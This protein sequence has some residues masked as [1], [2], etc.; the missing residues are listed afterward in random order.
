MTVDIDTVCPADY[1]QT[2]QRPPFEDL[3]ACLKSLKVDQPIWNPTT[4]RKFILQNRHRAARFRLEVAT[5]LS[6]IISSGLKWIED[7]DQKELIWEEASQ[8]LSER[9]GRAAMGEIIRRWPFRDR[10]TPFELII[11]EPPITGDSLGLKTWG[12]SY[13]MAQLLDKVAAG[14]LAHLNFSDRSGRQ[15]NVLE[16]GSGTGLLGMAAAAMWRANVVLS[17]LPAIMAN[18][19][20]NIEQNRGMIKEFGGNVD[21]GALTWGSLDAKAD[22]FTNQNGYKVILVADPLYDDDHPGLL[23][24]AIAENLMRDA[25][26]RAVVMVPQRDLTTKRLTAEFREKLAQRSSPLAVLEEHIL[27][28]QDD[29]DEDEG[30]PEVECWWAVFGRQAS[31]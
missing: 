1:P 25:D 27:T 11:R 26:A 18:L 7:D 30:K 9:C 10:V 8:R 6:S 2:W 3:L 17:D 15:I 28:V 13:L 23:S 20:F 12:S 21:S 19:N 16:L 22:L 29:W 24:S 31:L 4:S 14:P 5:Y